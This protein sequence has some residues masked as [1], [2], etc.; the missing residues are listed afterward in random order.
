MPVVISQHW[1]HDVYLNGEIAGMGTLLFCTTPEFPSPPI[2]DISSVTCRSCGCRKGACS[3]WWQ[4]DPTCLWHHK[5]HLLVLRKSKL[6][7]K[8]WIPPMRCWPLSEHPPPFCPTLPKVPE[9]WECHEMLENPVGHQQNEPGWT[10][11]PFIAGREDMY[12]GGNLF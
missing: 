3:S 5:L 9:D 10:A 7:N 11:I 8:Q 6:G 1:F 12:R 4:Q 2:R